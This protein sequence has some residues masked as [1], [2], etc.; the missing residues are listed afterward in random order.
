MSE[1]SKFRRVAVLGTGLIGG[2]FAL[3]VKRQIPGVVVAGYD[4]PEELQKARSRGAID[5]ACAD[6]PGAV[7]GAALVYIALPIVAAIR[8]L[9]EVAAAA[10]TGALVTDACSTKAAICREAAEQF[11]ANLGAK[12]LGGHPMAGREASGIENADA[13]L[14]HGARY[15]LVG[16]EPGDKLPEDARVEAFVGLLEKMG[17]EPVWF[18]AETHDW[19]AGI[20]SHLPQLVSIA[21]GRVIEDETDETGLPVSLA[22]GGLRDALRLAASPYSVW[23][24]ICLTNTE[25]VRRALDRMEQAVEYLRTHLTSR[26]LEKE[27]RAANEAYKALQKGQ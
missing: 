16:V 27:F 22:G 15:V 5:E 24:D 25:N 12:F 18:D 26:E 8:S 23:R 21:L 19:A 3:A 13:T 17:A 20:V 6:I 1:P 10:E 4:R 2:S 14:L 9:G 7:G 11:R